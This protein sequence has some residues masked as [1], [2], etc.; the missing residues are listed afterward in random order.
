MARRRS[1]SRSL[2]GY[3]T[4][5]AVV[6]LAPTLVVL[7]FMRSLPDS[8]SSGFK[9]HEADS[10]AG[11]GSSGSSSNS[12]AA[13]RPASRLHEQLDNAHSGRGSIAAKGA[14]AASLHADSAEQQQE[15]GELRQG[16]QGTEQQQGQQLQQGQ[17]RQQAQQGQQVRQGQVTRGQASL[18][19]DEPPDPQQQAARKQRFAAKK[20]QQAQQQLQPAAVYHGT[21]PRWPSTLPKGAGKPQA[22]PGCRDKDNAQQCA[23]WAR[24][25]DCDTNPGAA[26]RWGHGLHKG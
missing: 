7:T 11:S 20:A 8:S 4:L 10:M 25:G 15:Q 5:L 6:L 13:G 17:Q 18:Q 14:G 3:G 21:Y 12:R 19:P 9:K 22:L 26:A 24:Q 16:A 1:G 23:A 2:V